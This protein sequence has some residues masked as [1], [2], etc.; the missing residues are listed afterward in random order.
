MI[1]I[2]KNKCPQNHKCPAINFCPVQA[3][4]QNGFD[5]PIVN[6]ELCINCKKCVRFC[7]GRAIQYKKIDEKTR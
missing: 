7:P 3:I 2:D 1:I 5:L 4:T 6:H